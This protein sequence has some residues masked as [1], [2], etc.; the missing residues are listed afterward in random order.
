MKITLK[1]GKTIILDWNSIIFEYLCDYE[2]GLE[3]LKEDVKE[4]KNQMYIAN[5]IVY[6]VIRANID[7]DLTYRQ[8]ISLV[9]VDD[10]EKI[11]DFF[12]KNCNSNSSTTKQQKHKRH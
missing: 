7:E 1:N 8:A 12:N 9:N 11:I 3:A 5:H 2:G 10:I 6:S 4:E